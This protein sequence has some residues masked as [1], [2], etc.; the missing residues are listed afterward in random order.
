MKKNI[1]GFGLLVFAAGS[2]VPM[3][4]IN[5]HYAASKN[6]STYGYWQSTAKNIDI[7]ANKEF[8]ATW[9]TRLVHAVEV[10]GM[11]IY[12][13]KFGVDGETISSALGKNQLT[14]TLTAEGKRLVKILHK[15]E[16]N[17]CILGCQFVGQAWQKWHD[18]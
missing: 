15:L 7:W 17:H 8:R 12:P 14:G 11:I 16:K 9:N 5:R 10:D 13:Y 2:I 18:V 6:G 4:I 3:T 1:I